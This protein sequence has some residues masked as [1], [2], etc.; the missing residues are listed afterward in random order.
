MDPLVQTIP[1]TNHRFAGICYNNIANLQFKNGMF[2]VAEENY[3]LSIK[4]AMIC[5]KD[6]IDKALEK[7]EFEE[8]SEAYLKSEKF[9]EF[10]KIHAHRHY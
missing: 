9:L 4:K 2:S 1:M 10:A 3:K 5:A 6:A 8:P 7:G